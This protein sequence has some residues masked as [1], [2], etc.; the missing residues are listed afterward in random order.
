MAPDNGSGEYSL[1][2]NSWNPAVSGTNIDPTDWNSTADDV[3]TAVS[4]RIAKDGQTTPTANL[5]MGG[6]KHTGVNTNSGSASRS[7]YASGATVQDGAILDAGSTGGTSTAYTATL[8]PAITAYADKQCFRV[9]FN[10]ATGATPT[11]NFNSVGAKKLYWNNAGSTTQITTNDIPADYVAIL[12][13]DAALDSSAGGFWVLNF[14]TIATQ[15]E[16][17][18]GTSNARF[19]TPLSTVQ[20]VEGYTFSTLAWSVAA[21]GSA[22]QN[23]G[24]QGLVVRNISTGAS[25]TAS[26]AIGNNSDAA[27]GFISVNGSNNSS[28][29]GSRGVLLFANGGNLRLESKLGELQLIASTLVVS[30]TVYNTTTATAANVAVDSGG[31]IRRSTSSRRYKKNISDYGKGLAEI[32]A[33]RPVVYNSVNEG[34]ERTFAGLIA[35]EVHEAGFSEFVAYDEEGNPDALH[36]PHMIA[37]CV[38]ALKEMKQKN[39]ALEDRIALLEAPV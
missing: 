27:D 10:A 26:I 14:G 29:P 19:M 22:N 31:Q 37:L 16:A 23:S 2:S 1:P 21:Q 9:K 4:N 36:Y 20:L 28:G 11:I 18:A 13:Y 8:S 17:E 24:Y 6:F 32:M 33:L 38:A 34:D 35:E 15:A 3:E 5:P 12:R 39:D 25:A 30:Q 7:E